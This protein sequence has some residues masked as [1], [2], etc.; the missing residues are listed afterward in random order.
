MCINTV[1]N[2]QEGTIILRTFSVFID[3]VGLF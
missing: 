1:H 3:V 2:K